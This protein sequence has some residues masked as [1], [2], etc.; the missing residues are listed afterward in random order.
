MAQVLPDVLD[1]VQL[2]RARGQPDRRD[3]GRHSQLW[4]RVPTGAVEDEDGVRA[5]GDLG[6]D[7]VEVE[8][9]HLGVGEGQRQRRAFA[10][11]GTDRAEEIA[12]S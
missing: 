10:A 9:H 5:G 2:R 12:F 11:S 1:R 6:G 7:L 3:V 4:R 8:L